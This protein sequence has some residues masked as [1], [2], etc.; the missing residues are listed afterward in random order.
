VSQ[1]AS[2]IEPHL[3]PDAQSALVQRLQDGDVAALE[4]LYR[5]H[6]QVVRAFARRVLGNDELAEDLVHEVFLGAPGAFRRFRGESTVRTFLVGLAVNKAKHFVRAAIRR[7]RTI[8]ALEREPQPRGVAVPDRE[9]ERRELAGE[10]QRALD[11]LPVDERIAVVLCEVEERTSREV[12]VLV[13]APEATVRTRVFRAKRKLRE[14]L[15]G[16]R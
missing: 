10:L 9:H 2:A 3:G 14:M 12:A 16:E 4:M 13:G 6:H 7:R 1:Q 5:H 11:R 8:D 15:G